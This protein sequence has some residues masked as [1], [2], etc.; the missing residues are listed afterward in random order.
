MA[1]R[2]PK[3][4]LPAPF[5]KRIRFREDALPLPEEYPF[6]LPWLSDDFDFAF[7]KPVTIF[8]GENGTGKSTLIE[9]LAAVCGFSDAGGN[10]SV[11][12]A[13]SEGLLDV[14]G[15]RLAGMLRGSWLPKLTNGWFFRAETFF[16]MARTLDDL[17]SPGADFLSYSHGEGF[18]RF[19]E[20]RLQRQGIYLFD[21]PESALSPRSQIRFL[22]YLQRVQETAVSQVVMATHSPLLMAL[23]GADLW[24][25][26]HRGLERCSYRDT[27]HFRLWQSF[28]LDPESFVQA[29]CKEDLDSLL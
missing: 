3:I 28:S 14:N 20:E 9:A 6:D 8:C 13:A 19:F 12:A 5:L 27:E 15:G 25:I 22:K 1:R 18:L 2:N 10:R 23:P 24:R 17:G 21:E 4:S 7:E 29:A 16:S 26:T 11:A